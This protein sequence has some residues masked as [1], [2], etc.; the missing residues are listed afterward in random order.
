VLSVYQEKCILLTNNIR[1]Y[2]LCAFP[3]LTFKD[4]PNKLQVCKC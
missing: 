1:F 2:I 4:D 3:L